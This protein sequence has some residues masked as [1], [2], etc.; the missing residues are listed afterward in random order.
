MNGQLGTS[1][2][3]FISQCIAITSSFFLPHRIRIESSIPTRLGYLLQHV[4]YEGVQ[5]GVESPVLAILGGVEFGLEALKGCVSDD[6]G[7]NFIPQSVAGL[8]AREDIPLI[9]LLEN[10][11]LNGDVSPTSHRATSTVKVKLSPEYFGSDTG[12][13]SWRHAIDQLYSL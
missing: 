9:A 11:P 12:A 7:S 4:H 2:G 6:L 1:N 13:T 3:P 5:R 10:E 8:L